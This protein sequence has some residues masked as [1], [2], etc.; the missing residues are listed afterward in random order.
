MKPFTSPAEC[1]SV[2]N[3]LVGRRAHESPVDGAAQVACREREDHRHQQHLDDPAGRSPD[4]VGELV[5][6]LRERGHQQRARN[7]DQHPPE[8]GVVVP[9][10][11][12]QPNRGR[13]SHN[14]GTRQDG[15][16]G[17]LTGCRDRSRCG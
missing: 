16:I 2:K 15:Q 5:L 4:R 12:P 14:H 7:G 9:D 17:D 3:A 6:T 8:A 13:E 1:S 10:H 11:G